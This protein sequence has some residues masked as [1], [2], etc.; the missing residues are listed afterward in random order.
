VEV[1][2]ESDNEPSGS[3]KYWEVF[4]WLQDWRS[5]EELRFIKL[6]S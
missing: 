6:V 1:S 2:C 3:V 4:E 5:L